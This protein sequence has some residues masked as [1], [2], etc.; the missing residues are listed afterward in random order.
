MIKLLFLASLIFIVAPSAIALLI[1]TV[2]YLNFKYNVMVDA[3]N[4]KKLEESFKNI[5]VSNSSEYLNIELPES[6]IRFI[7]KEKNK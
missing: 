2:R 5:N 1:F 4:Q 3:H 6:P 7:E